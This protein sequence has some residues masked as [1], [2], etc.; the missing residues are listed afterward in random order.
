MAPSRTAPALAASATATSSAWRPRCAGQRWSSTASVTAG[1]RCAALRGLPRGVLAACSPVLFADYLLLSM[2]HGGLPGG[3]G[4][5]LGMPG[6]AAVL[7]ADAQAPSRPHIS[8]RWS[9]EYPMPLPSTHY[10]CTS[11]CPPARL[12]RLCPPRAPGAV[13]RPLLVPQHQRR[14]LAR[15][16][17]HHGCHPARRR[18]QR[19]LQRRHPRLVRGWGWVRGWG[20]WVRGWGGWGGE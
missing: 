5:V 20:G 6:S 13:L 15:R 7:W 18:R 4:P 17:R 10:P 9:T 19:A 1:V 3:P 11:A 8:F 14:L 2:H 12:P 16:Q